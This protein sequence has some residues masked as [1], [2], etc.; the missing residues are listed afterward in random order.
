M[1]SPARVLA[2]LRMRVSLGDVDGA[3]LVYFAAP[4]VWSERLMSE[5]MAELGHPMGR[6]FE[7][8][9]AVPVAATRTSFHSPLRQDDEIELRL[10]AMRIGTKSFTLATEVVR[11]GEEEPAVTVETTHVYAE[12]DGTEV[13]TRPMPG[14]L[15]ANLEGRRDQEREPG[16]DDDES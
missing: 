1:S 15:R 9:V 3:R 7:A 6:L 4:A 10:R 13:V 5:W 12:Q 8:G 2:S 11:R 14:W 16:G